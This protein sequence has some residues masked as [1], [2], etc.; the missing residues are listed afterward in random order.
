MARFF[1][2]EKAIVPSRT[3]F[4]SCE[5]EED[6]AAEAFKG[7]EYEGAVRVELCRVVLKNPPPFGEKR[8]LD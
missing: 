3:V 5:V 8:F 6:A 7:M 2:D 1:K 4:Y